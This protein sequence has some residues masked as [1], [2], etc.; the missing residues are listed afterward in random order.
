ML[1]KKFKSGTN[2]TGKV[3]CRQEAESI[4]VEDASISTRAMM[5]GLDKV[6]DS[7]RDKMNIM[8]TLGHIFPKKQGHN[9]VK[10]TWTF[11]LW[12]SLFTMMGSWNVDCSPR[13]TAWEDSCEVRKQHRGD[14]RE[15]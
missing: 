14:D 6:A 11:L 7:R 10:I 3:T 12:E 5:V 15:L 4:S 9:E 13:R 1:A 8:V 2:A